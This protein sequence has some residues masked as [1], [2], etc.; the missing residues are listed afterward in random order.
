MNIAIS[1]SSYYKINILKRPLSHFILSGL[2]DYVLTSKNKYN[3]LT[4]FILYFKTLLLL[5]RWDTGKVGDRFGG[6]GSLMC[7]G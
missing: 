5:L 3:V 4:V 7:K 2:K 1:V 6:M